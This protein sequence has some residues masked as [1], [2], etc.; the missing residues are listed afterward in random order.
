MYLH[1]DN[2][3]AMTH[4]HVTICFQGAQ[5]TWRT[6]MTHFILGRFLWSGSRPL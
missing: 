3:V 2:T 1:E 4:E 6:L 5:E